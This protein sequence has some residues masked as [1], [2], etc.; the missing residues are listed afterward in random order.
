MEEIN[1]A[2][3]YTKFKKLQRH[4][5]FL[6]L[7]EEYIKDEQIDRGENANESELK[8]KQERVEVFIPRFDHA[9]RDPDTDGRKQRRQENQP[10]IDA[11]DTEMQAYL[12]VRTIH[13][14]PVDFG[15]EACGTAQHRTDQSERRQEGDQRRP[16]R[17]C[18]R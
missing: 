9:L 5:E 6:E 14:C 2:D 12:E 13:P 17:N 16:K 4:L 1:E 7:Q 18:E 3:L 15:R 10:Q 11:V 8:Q